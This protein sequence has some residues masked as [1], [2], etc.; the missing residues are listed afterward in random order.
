VLDSALTT[1]IQTL[2][3]SLQMLQS[4]LLQLQQAQLQTVQIAAPAPAPAVAA[5]VAAVVRSEPRIKP[6]TL[7]EKERLSDMIQ[8]KLQEEHL[9]MVVQIIQDRMPHAVFRT[10]SMRERERER[11]RI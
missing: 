5:P 2:R 8:T 11:E 6:V 10:C 1:E 9:Q 4:Q 7:E 3:Q